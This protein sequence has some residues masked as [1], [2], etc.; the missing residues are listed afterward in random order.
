MQVTLTQSEKLAF[1]PH[2]LHD[3]GAYS[4][5]EDLQRRLPGE[6]YSG[7]IRLLKVL[8]TAFQATSVSSLLEA[9]LPVAAPQDTVWLLQAACL[10]FWR[11]C[12]SLGWE[13]GLR[14]EKFTLSYE[15]NIPRQSG[16]AGSSAIVCAALS[17]L[18]SFYDVGDRRACAPAALNPLT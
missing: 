6:G 5:L 12:Q 10:V 1:V 16:L 9:A 17:C 7:G 13:A 18:Y 11:H 4:S 3:G 14:A 2:P 8:E 15:T